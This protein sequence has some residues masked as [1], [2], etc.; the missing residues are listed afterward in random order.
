MLPRLLFVSPDN[1]KYL[2]QL[3]TACFTVDLW[4]LLGIDLGEFRVYVTQGNDGE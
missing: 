1:K 2:T 3:G 4:Q